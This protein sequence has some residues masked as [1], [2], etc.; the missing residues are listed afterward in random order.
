MKNES[1]Q[2]DAQKEEKEKMVENYY[3]KIM[4]ILE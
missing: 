3:R 1:S 2:K 4:R